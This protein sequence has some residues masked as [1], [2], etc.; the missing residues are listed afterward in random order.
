M[1]KIVLPI[2]C[3]VSLSFI[4]AVSAERYNTKID[5]LSFHKTLQSSK[6]Y[7]DRLDLVKN[8]LMGFPEDPFI[9]RV[10]PA[11][12]QD[13]ESFEMKLWFS[14]IFYVGKRKD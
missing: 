1:K 5:T 2:L 14:K 8:S 10:K 11:P 3:L 7:V 4:S 6:D 13:P 9:P 12:N